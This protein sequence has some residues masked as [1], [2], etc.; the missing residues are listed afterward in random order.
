[1]Y[2]NLEEESRNENDFSTDYSDY[3]RSLSYEDDYEDSEYTPFNMGMNHVPFVLNP[4]YMPNPQYEIPTMDAIDMRKR[5]KRPRPR[6][7][8]PNPYAYNPYYYGYPQAYNKPYFNPYYGQGF[9]PLPW[10]LLGS[11]F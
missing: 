10:F 4:Y 8:Y 9:N 2:V 11:I 1:M 5:P 7:K 6:P 3:F